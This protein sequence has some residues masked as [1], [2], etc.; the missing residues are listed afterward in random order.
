MLPLRLRPNKDHKYRVY[1]NVYHHLTGYTVVI[2]SIVNVFKGFAILDP[3]EKWK[4]V[5]I[6]IIG[7]LGSIALPLEGITW[8]IYSINEEIKD[9]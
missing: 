5:Y 1:W 2:L 8:Y 9:L 4:K 7:V 3:K 6:C